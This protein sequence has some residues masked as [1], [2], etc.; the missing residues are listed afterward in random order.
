MKSLKLKFSVLMFDDSVF[1]L[2]VLWVTV[3]SQWELCRV[4]AGDVNCLVL[5]VQIL[6]RVLHM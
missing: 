2:S 4:F 1:T 5:V 3:L 6:V